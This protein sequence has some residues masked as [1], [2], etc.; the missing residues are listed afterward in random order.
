[1]SKTR[2]TIMSILCALS[3]LAFAPVANAA[4]P[5]CDPPCP[6][7]QVCK[8]KAAAG[9]NPPPGLLAK[10]QIASYPDRAKCYQAKRSR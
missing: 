1:M 6:A 4:S 7:G 8:W 3:S 9:D 2:L 10:I 5:I